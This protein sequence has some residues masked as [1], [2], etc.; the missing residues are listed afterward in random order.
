M[1]YDNAPAYEALSFSYI[2]RAVWLHRCTYAVKY[3]AIHGAPPNLTPEQVKGREAVLNA[4]VKI[5]TNASHREMDK[6]VAYW[7]S[8]RTM[9]P[10]HE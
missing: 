9:E 8:Y 6:A 4:A 3:E 7:Q 2:E 1:P 5:L 10:S